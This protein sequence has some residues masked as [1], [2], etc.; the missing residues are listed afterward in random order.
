MGHCEVIRFGARARSGTPSPLRSEELHLTGTRL[1]SALLVVLFAACRPAAPPPYVLSKESR[2]YAALT[3]A[4][5]SEED[6]E[7]DG[8]RRPDK[9]LELAGVREG[10]A[11]VDLMAGG[12]WYTEVLARVVGRG[13]R[14]V[15]QNSGLSDERYGSVLRERLAKLGLGNVSLEVQELDALDL[16]A[17]SLDAVFL[18]QFYHDTY[19]MEVDRSAMNRAVFD[20]L[21]VGGV[22]LVI[23]HSAEPGSGA[24][25]VE[26]LHRIDEDLVLEE[27]LAAGFSLEKASDL[28]RN[29]ADSR[30]LS[31]FRRAIRGRSDRF[32]LKFA[33]PSR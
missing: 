7:R 31:V 12:G 6:R 19:W 30:E 24:E 2:F 5:R 33:K 8:Y 10:M 15:A 27:I 9:I 22:Y 1:G 20:A 3:A 14:V 25:H 13:G 23:D 29:D 28:L 4:G 17:S 16:P 21:K 32:V 11:I 26:T 18:V